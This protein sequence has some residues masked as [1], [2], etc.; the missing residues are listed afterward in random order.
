MHKHRIDGYAVILFFHQCK[1]GCFVCS[2][3]IECRFFFS[4]DI[5]TENVLLASLQTRATT[6]PPPKSS[7]RIGA[8]LSCLINYIND[9]PVTIDFFSFHNNCRACGKWRTISLWISIQSYVSS[10]GFLCY[11]P[12][13]WMIAQCRK[14]QKIL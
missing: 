2:F 8:R 1:G 11:R 13:Y 9:N 3:V 14:E 12:G 6:K 5:N 10:L 4:I 7:Q